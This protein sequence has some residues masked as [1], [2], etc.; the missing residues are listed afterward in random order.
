MEDL[1]LLN[2]EKLDEKA[3]GQVFGVAD[4]A[5]VWGVFILSLA[6]LP[7]TYLPANLHPEGRQMFA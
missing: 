5:S 4:K 7:V 1:G 2:K 3:K 6:P